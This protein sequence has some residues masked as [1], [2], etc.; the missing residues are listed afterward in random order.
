MITNKE[1]FTSKEF[2]YEKIKKRIESVIEE[3]ILT[4]GEAVINLESDFPADKVV[5]YKECKCSEGLNIGKAAVSLRYANE[6]FF[7]CRKCG[8][9]TLF[10]HTSAKEFA[11]NRLFICVDPEK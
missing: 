11:P 4:N 10:T 3:G 1:Y 9:K 8:F 6:L 2:D 7:Q 5:V